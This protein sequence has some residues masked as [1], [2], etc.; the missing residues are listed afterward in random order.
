[1]AKKQFIDVAFDFIIWGINSNIEDYRL[2]IFL[3]QHLKWNFKRVHDIEFYSP[4]IKAVK[5]FNAYKYKND[6][7]LYTVELIQNKNS[8]NILIPEL[9]NIDFIFLLNGEE[10]YF[11]KETFTDALS[12]IAG[13]Q[14]VLPIDV[15]S[16]KSKH[17]LLIR[18]FNEE[19]K[20]KN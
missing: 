11:D 2:C 18:H 9:K 10:E 15:N 12:K 20:K 6:A 16:L 7:D 4:Q 19:P 17:N 5:H 8:G 13:V 14:S 1:M 3:N